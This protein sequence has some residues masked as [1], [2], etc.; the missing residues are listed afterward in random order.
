[1]IAIKACDININCWMRGLIGRW[2]GDHNIAST[3]G[4]GL[5][6]SHLSNMRQ[7]MMQ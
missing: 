3:K 2:T 4:K 1:M 7:A 5:E 6:P